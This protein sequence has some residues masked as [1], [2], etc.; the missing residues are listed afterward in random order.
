MPGMDGTGPQGQGPLTGGGFGKCSSEAD[1]AIYAG[2]GMGRG[3]GF[4]RYYRRSLFG[5]DS[6]AQ[7]SE[8]NEFKAKLQMLEEKMEQLSAE[9]DRLRSE[10]TELKVK[11]TK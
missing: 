10:N 11:K 9:N 5:T 4:H 8:Q 1:P 2:R 7:N 6:A 3:R